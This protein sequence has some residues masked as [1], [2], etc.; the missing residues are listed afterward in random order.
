MTAL[1]SPRCQQLLHCLFQQLD[2]N[3]YSAERLEA[4]NAGRAGAR[5]STRDLPLSQ[6]A[7]LHAEG[8]P[9]GCREFQMFQASSGHQ[10]K[11]RQRS[12]E[13]IE[14]QK[15]KKKGSGGAW[16]AY[17]H[18]SA[19]GLGSPDLAQ[20][21]E[22]CWMLSDEKYQ[23]YANLGQQAS[24]LKKVYPDQPAFPSIKSCFSQS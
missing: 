1:Q 7:T 4:S 23:H 19:Q 14:D 12:E 20:L 15:P 9:I 17:I 13:V 24:R 16:R 21:A 3:T 5:N 18:R 2:G 10:A 8:I 11:K 22:Q 6:A